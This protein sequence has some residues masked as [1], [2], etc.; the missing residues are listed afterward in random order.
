M[1]GAACCPL[2]ADSRSVQQVHELFSQ[3]SSTDSRGSRR[4]DMTF[5]LASSDVK[6]VPCA[7][8]RPCLLCG[9]LYGSRSIQVLPVR[10]CGVLLCRQTCFCNLRPLVEQRVHRRFMMEFIAGAGAAQTTSTGSCEHEKIAQGLKVRACM[11]TLSLANDS[12]I[13]SLACQRGCLWLTGDPHLIPIFYGDHSRTPGS[14]ER[15]AP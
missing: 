9:T 12:A 8:L 10:M 13:C 11:R 14:L 3:P 1:L 15:R 6:C 7:T 2:T 5:L 4:F